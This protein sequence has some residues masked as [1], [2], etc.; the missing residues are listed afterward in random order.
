MKRI[1]RTPPLFNFDLARMYA[2]G[3]AMRRL[4]TVVIIARPKLTKRTLI[5]ACFEKKSEKLETANETGSPAIVKVSLPAGTFFVKA[6]KI[7]SRSGTTTNA[8]RKT[9]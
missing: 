1:R 7:I 9:A 6:Y 3:Y 4:M 5:F 2:T 8:I